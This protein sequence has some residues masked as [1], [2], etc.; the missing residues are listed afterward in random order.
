MKSFR[1]ILLSI[2]IY[3]FIK[4]ISA[5]EKDFQ[6]WTG[7]TLK[8]DIADKIRISLEEGFRFD[9]NASSLKKYYTDV[10]LGY[11]L[12]KPLRI[13]AYY[14]FTK[15]N[16]LTHYETRH[17]YYFDL[18]FKHRISQVNFSLRSRYQ[19]RYIDA[20]ERPWISET[21]QYNRNKVAVKY[22]IQNNPVTPYISGELFYAIN[23]SMGS[24]INKSRIKVGLEYRINKSHELELSYM[25]QNELNTAYPLSSYVLGINYTVDL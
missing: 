19:N 12:F 5:Q 7:I 24:Y 13:S 16:E 20:I 2:V 22:D 1:F 6:V 15:A 23:S 3:L 4:S 10:G 18:L 9:Q 11:Y 17:R 14:R 21:H 8:K 25:I